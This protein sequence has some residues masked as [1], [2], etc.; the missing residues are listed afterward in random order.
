MNNNDQKIELNLNVTFFTGSWCY[1]FNSKGEFIIYGNWEHSDTPSTIWSE[2]QKNHKIIWIYSTKTRNNK[3]ICKRLYEI[4]KNFELISI[5]KDNKLY[6]FS[7][8]YIYEWNLLTEKSIKLFG[9]ENN[10]VQKLKKD[11]GIFSN[12]KFICLRTVNKIIIY[13]N[14]NH[15]IDINIFISNIIWICF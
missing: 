7:N 5:S 4:P 13:F 1:N 11:I 8:N 9:E 10:S 3:W 12:E 15:N 6:L 14:L 2:Y